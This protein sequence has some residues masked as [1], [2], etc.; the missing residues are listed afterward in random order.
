MSS[1]IS[2]HDELSS[3]RNSVAGRCWRIV[4]AQNQISTTKLTDSSDEQHALERLIEATKPP[5]P[6]ECRHLHFLL[7]T[8]FRYGSA[9]PQGSR[10][11]RAGATPGVFYASETVDTA[12]AELCFHRLLFF[13]ESPR[14]KWP[15]VA[16]EYTA[17]AA[18]YA[19]ARSIDLMSPQFASRSALWMHVT[20]Y[21][22]CQTL[23]DMA[24]QAEVELVRYASVRDPA[25]NANIAILSCR[26]FAAVEPAAHQTWRLLF[27]GN[28]ARAIREWPRRTIDFNREAFLP[29]PR[30]AAMNW[31]R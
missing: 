22:A 24:R 8:P 13:A 9:Y 17:F 28:G 14:T 25:H 19:T 29:D 26:A 30:V 27:G 1:T 3:S 21:S 23:A 5:V 15:G 2:T 10:F 18:D 20:D 12:V 4:E 7:F 6:A 31:E 16:G 11:R